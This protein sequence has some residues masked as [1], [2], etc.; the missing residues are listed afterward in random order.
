MPEY[1]IKRMAKLRATLQTEE[2]ALISGQ[3]DR[4]QYKELHKS[5]KRKGG[6]QPKSIK[7]VDLWVDFQAAFDDGDMKAAV[8]PYFKLKRLIGA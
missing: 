1:P 3:D 5:L 4:P 7:A 2:L 6:G 8:I